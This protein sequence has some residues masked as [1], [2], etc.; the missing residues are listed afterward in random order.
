RPITRTNENAP[1]A[2]GVFVSASRRRLSDEWR[3]RCQR[4]ST[5]S[6][7]TRESLDL[8]GLGTPRRPVLKPY[9]GAYDI[10]VPLL[11]KAKCH[12]GCLCTQNNGANILPI[13]SHQPFDLN[14]SAADPPP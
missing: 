9:L 13:C 2:R 6:V 14:H 11:H 3:R 1:N 4:R 7:R 5:I 12:H 8:R 10:T